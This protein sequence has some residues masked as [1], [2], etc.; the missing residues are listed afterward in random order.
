MRD[1]NSFTYLALNFKWLAVFSF[2]LAEIEVVY[3]F[4][5]P[6][7]LRS[8]LEEFFR[9]IS[10]INISEWNQDGLLKRIY[11]VFKV[12]FTRCNQILW[13]LFYL[14][15]FMWLLKM[16]STL[17]TSLFHWLQN[18]VNCCNSHRLIAKIRFDIICNWRVANVSSALENCSTRF[19]YLVFIW[20]SGS[21]KLV[22]LIIA[23]GL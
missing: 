2:L 19:W 16:T 18:Y 23:N 9:A 17:K 22:L 15:H 7:V 13:W 11:A 20:P 1:V 3:P 12:H 21:R 14:F 6:D 5:E 10:P 4:Q 8:V